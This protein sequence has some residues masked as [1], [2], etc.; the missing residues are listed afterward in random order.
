MTT[1]PT[2]EQKA[3]FR[4]IAHEATMQVASYVER[5]SFLRHCITDGLL[6]EEEA[7]NHE[8]VQQVRRDIE[9]A[10]IRAVLKEVA[11]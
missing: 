4:R 1:S 5:F 6:T 7:I 11:A 3:T 2:P 10:K 8:E 9:T